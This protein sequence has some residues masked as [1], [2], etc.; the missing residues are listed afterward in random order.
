[1]GFSVSLFVTFGPTALAAELGIKRRCSNGWQ[2][3]GCI[4]LYPERLDGSLQ[5]SSIH[6]NE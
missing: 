2:R 4:I 6:I 3:L 1:M 5:D